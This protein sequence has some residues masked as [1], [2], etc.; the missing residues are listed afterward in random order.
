MLS[1]LVDT[2][3]MGVVVMEPSR[4]FR[5][6]YCNRTLR[7]GPSS[8][9]P[10]MVGRPFADAFATSVRN[11]VIHLLRGVVRTG[12]AV[13]LHEFDG[14]GDRPAT[15]LGAGAV[16]V[17]NWDVYPLRDGQGRV[18]HLV[19]VGVDVTSSVSTRRRVDEA[20]ERGLLALREMSHQMS[21][22]LE[23]P[24]FYGTV[25]ASVAQLVGARRAFFGRLRDDGWLEGAPDG[26][27][28][29]SHVLAG[30]RVPCRRGGTGLVERIVFDDVVFHSVL[31]DDPQLEPYR[32]IVDSLQIVEVMAVSW[33]VDDQPVGVL[34][35]D[36]PLR[37][38]FA[39]E[40]ILV[41]RTAALAAALVW[42]LRGGAEVIR[43]LL[44]AAPDAMVAIGADGRIQ[45][46]NGELETLFGYAET[47]LHGQSVEVL[48]PRGLGASEPRR[49]SQD[50]ADPHPS[51]TGVTVELS[52][53]RSDGREFPVEVSHGPLSTDAGM[54]V[55]AAIRDITTRRQSERDL[56]TRMT[57]LV[58]I[59]STDPLSGL[60]NR[61]EFERLLILSRTAGF[62]VLAIDI[63]GLKTVNDA[64]G[65]EAGDAHLRAVASTLRMAM[66][67]GDL[68]ARTGGDEFAALLPGRSLEEATRVAERL[69]KSMHGVVVPHGF[70]RISVGCAAGTESSDRAKVAG[71]DRVVASPPGSVAG[72]SLATWETTLPAIIAGGRI[73]AVYQPIVRLGDGSVF[74]Y[75]ALGRRR[76]RPVAAGAD[77]LFA[78]AERLGLYRDLDWLCRRV[79]V[80]DARGLPAGGLLFLNVGVSALLDPVHGADQMLLLLRWGA[81]GPT[82]VVLE[83]S[84]RH[85]VGETGR[86]REVLTEYRQLGFRFALDD[87]GAGLS[88]FEVLAAAAPEFV[89][90]SPAIT[91]HADESGPRAVV[92]ALAAF[93]AET[94][95]ALI[96]EG[97]ETGD[98]V[99]R[100]IDLGVGLGQGFALGEPALP[101]RSTSAPGAGK[102]P[103][104]DRDAVRGRGEDDEG[105]EDLVIPEHRWERIRSFEAVDDRPRRVQESAD[106][107][108]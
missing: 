34:V 80:R 5:I 4:G 87:V 21:A 49:R 18:R 76:D 60:P 1:A 51:A 103:D 105:V 24:A 28:I 64:H 65:H 26:F 38:S 37:G 98:D 7:Q 79:A 86:L 9:P 13:H 2:L 23:L 36:G 25:S 71:R 30:L 48:L 75:E 78:A 31:G 57:E 56:A 93:V 95:S 62:A 81:L 6:V 106:H 73:R 58:G 94:G 63:D 46:V 59:A 74:G 19:G 66:R 89:K 68:V 99:L 52:G 29:A 45:L 102:D 72:S 104:V 96:A 17:W 10:R 27:G 42:Q 82:R 40:D 83:I 107:E 41:L 47:E 22:S 53:R 88:T 69:R 44:E 55:V 92:R 16:S 50:A 84:E 11:R 33:R 70:A 3:P 61:R 35:V 14:S 101:P 90:V 108:E 8:R 77:G 67:D 85:A 12:E 39:P 43:G 54:L 97:L 91:R 32:D 100:M 15:T 20:H